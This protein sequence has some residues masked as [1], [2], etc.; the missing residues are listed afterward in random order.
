MTCQFRAISLPTFSTCFCSI[1]VLIVSDN[2]KK[3]LYIKFC[4]CNETKEPLG[5]PQGMSGQGQTWRVRGKRNGAAAAVAIVRSHPFQLP[6]LFPSFPIPQPFA[7]SR[8]PLPRLDP[9]CFGRTLA[10]GLA[11]PPL[12]LAFCGL[13]IIY[14]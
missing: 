6:S 5:V 8:H 4:L 2:T 13:S 12:L 11:P 7:V 3:L 9:R 1:K 14:T 10:A